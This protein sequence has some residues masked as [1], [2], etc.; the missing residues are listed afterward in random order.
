MSDT[1]YIKFDKCVAVENKQVTIGDVAK[2]ECTNKNI[3]NKLKTIKI[4]NFPDEK[5]NR[6]VF[7]ALKVIELILNEYPALQITHIGEPDVV[8][9]LKRS[10]RP[11]E[12]WQ[13]IKVII[14]C[15]ITFFGA[16]FAIMTFNED[17]SVSK[18]FQLLYHQITGTESSGYTVIEI[19]YS[20]GLAVGILVFYNHFGRK[21]VTKDPTPIEVEMRLYEDD[22]NKTLIEGV[23]RKESHIDV[24]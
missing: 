20:I 23:K 6:Y 24:N 12:I 16:A 19:T 14:I 22:I 10:K 9:E 1:L 3:L 11:P 2:L 17:V 15:L 8:I 18:V 13:I 5:H 4:M 7:S 21:K